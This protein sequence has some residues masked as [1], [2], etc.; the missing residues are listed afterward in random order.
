L[1]DTEVLRHVHRL[2]SAN[3]ALA[4]G[5]LTALAMQWT[6]DSPI[7]FTGIPIAGGLGWI[8]AP[9]LGGTHPRTMNAIL[10]MALACAVLG[11]YGTALL[12]STGPS[13][14]ALAIGTFGVLFFGVPAFVLLLAPATAWA[15]ITSWLVRHAGERHVTPGLKTGSGPS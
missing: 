1:G 3:V 12:T 8:L 14:G 13:L 7:G 5:V 9:R 11:A 4:V 10:L 6:S 2:R 15:V